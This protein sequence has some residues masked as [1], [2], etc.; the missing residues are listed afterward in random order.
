[1]NAE[2]VRE[3]VDVGKRALR[4][5]LR[6]ES[7][8]D[9][10]LGREYANEMQRLANRWHKQHALKGVDFLTHWNYQQS[11]VS[12]RRTVGALATTIVNERPRGSAGRF[13]FSWTQTDASAGWEGD[14]EA[15]SVRQAVEDC[16]RIDGEMSP[17]A[18]AFVTEL[19]LNELRQG[20]LSLPRLKAVPAANA[21]LSALRYCA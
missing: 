4:A 2:A 11:L 8:A 20:R 9:Q 5:Y 18:A 16:A 21:E 14:G 19:L 7:H 12:L 3:M 10:I 15:F 17:Q 13:V 1:M 6:N